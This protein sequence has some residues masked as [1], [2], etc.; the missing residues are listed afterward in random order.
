[1][2]LFVR[3]LTSERR[4]AIAVVRVWGTKAV[5][6]VDAVFRPARGKPLAETSP[7]RLRLGRAG[8][9]LGDEVVAVRLATDMP[10]VEIQCHGGAAAVGSVV[11]A[12]EA[13]GARRVDQSDIGQDQADD[14][15]AT[16]A[17][18]DLSLA[19]TLRT[20]EILLDQVHGALGRE[21]DRL[22]R[23]VELAA[24][25]PLAALDRLIGRAAVGLRLLSGWKVA[26]AG[27]PN[28]G[29][30][31]LFN[32]LAGFDRAIVRP[33]ARRDAGCRDDSG[34]PSAAG[35]SSSPTRR[36]SGRPKTPS[37]AWGSRGRGA[38]RWTLTSCCWC[39]TGPSFSNPRTTS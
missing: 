2:D 25:P 12:L 6:V 19:P 26:I 16:Q 10:T 3:V 33:G 23:K 35:P 15:L 20:A 7:G 37:R 4:G 14:P 39:S 36:A 9:G 5:E 24:A 8:L 29:K 11:A 38:N 17:L 31:R 30:S 13:A 27:R 18:V 22:H 1:M 32:A 21:I 34:P 28:V